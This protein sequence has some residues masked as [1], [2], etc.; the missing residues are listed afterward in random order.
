MLFKIHAM[1]RPI[2]HLHKDTIPGGALRNFLKGKYNFTGD[3]QLVI[4]AGSYQKYACLDNIIHACAGF[5]DNVK[6]ILMAYGL[7]DNLR[8]IPNNCVVVPP[9]KGDGFYNWLV[10][11]DCALLP[12]E[13]ESDFNVKNCSPQK[14][15]DCY[16]VGVPF[17]ASNRPI[18][19]KILSLCPESGTI[20][21]FKKVDQLVETINRMIEKKIHVSARMRRLHKEKLNYDS[22]SE[23]IKNLLE[24]V[25]A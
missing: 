9:V 12:Y 16:C 14:I 25:Y 21:D 4:Y 23:S 5:K 20:C 19:N 13:D 2:V 1:F 7:P 10:D 8:Q 15:F 17:V 11:A 18:I 24:N 22:M 6:L 3:E